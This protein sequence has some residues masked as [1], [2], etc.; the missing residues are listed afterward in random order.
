MEDGG[1]E[2]EERDWRDRREEKKRM[3]VE[4][5]S[6]ERRSASRRVAAFERTC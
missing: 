5:T 1:N 3:K 2:A 4:G 6:E